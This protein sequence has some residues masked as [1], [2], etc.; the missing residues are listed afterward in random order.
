MSGRIGPNAVNG[1]R[2][3]K[4]V[5]EPQIC[6]GA[7]CHFYGSK[8]TDGYCSQC[9]KEKVAKVKDDEKL[10][11]P[12]L[13]EPLAATSTEPEKSVRPVQ[14]KKKR[15]WNCN[16]R[17]TPAGR[18]DCK[19]GYIYCTRCRYPDVHNCLEM[20]QRKNDKKKEITDKNKKVVGA[21]L[22]R[23]NSFGE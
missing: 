1:Q 15:C 4:S 17:T 11:L 9:F 7:N 22:N 6:R 12:E 14:K 13:P 10:A 8:N 18:F 21:K 2:D 16:K 20:E 23:I 3:E 19:C 5:D